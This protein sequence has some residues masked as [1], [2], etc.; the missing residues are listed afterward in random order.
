MAD[1]IPAACLA[2]IKEFEGLGDGDKTK[3]GLQPYRD[4]AGILTIAW[5]STG[6]HVKEGMTITE[7]EAE[8]LLSRDV[9]R[10]ATAVDDACVRTPNENQRA[11][12]VAFTYNVG[13]AAFRKSTVLRAFNAYD[14]AA[15][16]RAFGL[17]CKA[18]INGKKVDVPGLVRRRAAEA[19][20]Y[21]KPVPTASPAPAAP[22]MTR[23]VE[24]EKPL[25]ASKTA[26]AGGVGAA[27]VGAQQA[28]AQVE[29]VWNGLHALGIRPELV[30]AIV[31]V[32]A[33][34]AAVLVVYERIQ[35]RRQGVA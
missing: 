18:T 22:V 3:P 10:I 34:G 2:L 35:K 7:A 24:P 9:A 16:A 14:D 32:I 12:M 28:I 11:A 33:L 5:G 8:K 15:A 4:V 19:A 21:L 23:A 17:W 1:P 25:T 27:M 26:I 13:A 6:P 30:L 29:P 20:L 31:G